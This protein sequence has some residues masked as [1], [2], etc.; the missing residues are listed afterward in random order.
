MKATIYRVDS[1][2]GG[3]PCYLPLKSWASLFARSNRG[4]TYDEKTSRTVVEGKPTL[5]KML[6]P[7]ELTARQVGAFMKLMGH[8]DGERYE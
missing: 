6:A 8:D 5:C 1:T 3:D 4:W 7:D 2:T